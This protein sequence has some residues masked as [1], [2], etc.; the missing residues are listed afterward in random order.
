MFKRKFLN[1]NDEVGYLS[2]SFEI[3]WK[4]YE[5]C[6]EPLVFNDI[7]FAIYEVVAGQ[8]FPDLV[9]PKKRLLREEYRDTQKMFDI[10]CDYVQEFIFRKI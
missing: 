5:A 3:R 9:E 10:C 6:V 4:E 7:D 8:E 2:M 1:E